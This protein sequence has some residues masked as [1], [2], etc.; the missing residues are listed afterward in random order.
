MGMAEKCS[1]VPVW[2]AGPFADRRVLARRSAERRKVGN[3]KDRGC[4]DREEESLVK[5][6][7]EGTGLRGEVKIAARE[8]L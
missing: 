3:S 8:P 7:V 2:T 5:E 1:A 6:R 4:G